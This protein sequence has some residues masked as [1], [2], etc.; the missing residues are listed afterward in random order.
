V[1]SVNDH[2][3]KEL[4]LPADHGPEGSLRDVLLVLAQEILETLV[5]DTLDLVYL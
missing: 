3:E 2:W 4:E 1:I 5:Q